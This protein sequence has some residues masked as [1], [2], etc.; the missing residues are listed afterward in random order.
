MCVIIDKFH[1]SYSISIHF[2]KKEQK[3]SNSEAVKITFP[4]HGK[5]QSIFCY[6]QQPGE[7]GWCPTCRIGETNCSEKEGLKGNNILFVSCFQYCNLLRLLK[8]TFV[9]ITQPTYFQFHLF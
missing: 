9:N 1:F 3:V 5:N 8:S 6:N 4:N 7:L 2:Y